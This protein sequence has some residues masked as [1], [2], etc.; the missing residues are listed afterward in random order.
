M[1]IG[2]LLKEARK[3][4]GLTLSQVAKDIFIQE[5]YLQALEEGNYDAIPGE[6]YQRAFFRTYADYLGLGDYIDGLT[7][8]HRFTPEKEEPPVDEIFGGVWDTTRWARVAAKLG[9]IAVI[10]LCLVLAVRAARNPSEQSEEPERVSSTQTLEVAPVD[11]HRSWDYPKPD[12]IAASGSLPGQEHELRLAALG[13]CW[14]RVDT[15]DGTMFTGSLYTGDGR[16][17]RHP[18]GFYLRA[19]K[20]DVLEVK[21]DGE[22]VQ[23]EQGQN[24]MTLPPGAAV[25]SAEDGEASSGDTID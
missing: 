6:A 25:L 12:E 5:K 24:R 22:R 18:V 8:P 9:L 23:W 19:G 20:P 15:P 14:V 2:E 11:V 13:E 21:F 16:V 10:I 1:K 17:F 4:K 7:R 3:D